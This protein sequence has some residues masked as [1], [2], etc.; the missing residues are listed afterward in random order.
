MIG[1]DLGHPRWQYAGLK[2]P[3]GGGVALD[4]LG[5]VFER[6]LRLLAQLAELLAEELSP[7][8]RAASSSHPCPFRRRVVI[9]DLAIVEPVDLIVDARAGLVQRTLDE[10]RKIE[11]VQVPAE[12]VLQWFLEHQP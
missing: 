6:Q 11:H 4:V 12:L 5:D 8:C 2:A 10:G 3:D 1:Q 9:N 7:Q